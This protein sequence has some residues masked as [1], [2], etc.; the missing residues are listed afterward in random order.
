VFFRAGSL[1][2]CA[3]TART[4][5]LSILEATLHPANSRAQTSIKAQA[6]IKAQSSV[7][8]QTNARRA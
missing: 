4:V 7:K 1:Y 5:G 8:A 3:T 6:S 2:R